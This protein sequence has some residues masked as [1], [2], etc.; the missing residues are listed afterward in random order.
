MTPAPLPVAKEPVTQDNIIA[1]VSSWEAV[2]SLGLSATLHR[3]VSTN[4]SVLVGF[5]RM[6]K[7]DWVA[8]HSKDVCI[9]CCNFAWSLD[10]HVACGFYQYDG[11][12]SWYQ[13]EHR[14]VKPLHISEVQDKL[15]EELPRLHLPFKFAEQP[16]YQPLATMECNTWGETPCYSLPGTSTKEQIKPIPGK[17]EAY[18][19]WYHE[20]YLPHKDDWYQD[21]AVEAP[22]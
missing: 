12:S 16:H 13:L 3:L 8:L 9:F 4:D 14:P 1:E 15:P 18:R 6:T 10:H 7:Q 11:D 5:D 17:E 2:Q 21:I 22:K 19:K 20:E